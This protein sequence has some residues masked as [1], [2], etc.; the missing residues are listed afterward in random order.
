MD[1]S[2]GKFGD[3]SFS[4][5]SFIVITDRQTES[6]TDADERLTKATSITKKKLK[7]KLTLWIRIRSSSSLSICSARPCTTP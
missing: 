3:C 5:F 4:R 7:R 2:Y 1:Y 6:H